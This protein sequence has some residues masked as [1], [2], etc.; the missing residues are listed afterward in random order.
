MTSFY[1]QEK[2]ELEQAHQ[3]IAELYARM[4][5][6]EAENRELKALVGE[7]RAA[8]EKELN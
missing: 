7:L 4:R 3:R 5:V 1:G 2:R 8:L 6:M